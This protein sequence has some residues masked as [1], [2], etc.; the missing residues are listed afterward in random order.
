MT[1]KLFEL[2]NRSTF[3]PIF[4]FRCRPTVAAV[5]ERISHPEP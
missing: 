3:I 4:A 5:S 1:L 2:R